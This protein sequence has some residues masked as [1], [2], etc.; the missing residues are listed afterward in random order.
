MCYMHLCLYACTYACMSM[1]KH[2]GMHAI[3]VWEIPESLAIFLELLVSKRVEI[4][5]HADEICALVIL[6]FFFVPCSSFYPL[7]TPSPPPFI[8]AAWAR[9]HWWTSMWTKS[10]ATSTKQP[11]VLTFSPRR[12]M[13]MIVLLLC[14]CVCN[15]KDYSFFWGVIWP[16]YVCTLAPS[17]FEKKIESVCVF[18]CV[19]VQ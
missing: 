18:M 3:S 15:V 6:S 19:C 10:S 14:R 7:C 17:L 13:L 16:V 8:M 9:L 11:S 4:C 5:T 12:S 1:C 2:T